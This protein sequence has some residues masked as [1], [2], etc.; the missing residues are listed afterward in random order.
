M[1]RVCLAIVVVSLLAVP[2]AAEAKREPVTARADLVKTLLAPAGIGANFKGNHMFVTGTGGLYVYDIT[3]GD[4]PQLVSTLP[5]PHYENEDVSIGGNRLLLSGDGT[6]GGGMVT[7]VDISN[8]KVPIIERVIKLYTLGGPGH[9]ATCIQGCKYAWVAGYE[10]IYVLNL[11]E[12]DEVPSTTP[13]PGLQVQSGASKVEVGDLAIAREFGWSTHDVQV[14]EAG[15]AWVVGGDGTAAFD[16]RPGSYPV[17]GKPYPQNLLEPKLVARTGPAALNDGDVTGGSP[18]D[19]NPDTVN[20]FIHHNSWRPRANGFRSRTATDLSKK[21]VRTGE[22]VLI[23]EEDIWNRVTLGSTPGG[24]ET[25]GSFQTWQVKQFGAPDENTS[26]VSNLDRWT[27]E[28]NETITGDETPDGQDIVPTKG[29][30]SSHYFS[31]RKNIVATAWYEQGTR[32]LD[33]S[34]PSNIK[35]VAYFM[36]PGST[37]WAAYWSPTDDNVVYVVDNNRGVDVVRFNRRAQEEAAALGSD[38]VKAPIPD[39]WATDTADATPD[40]KFSWVCRLPIAP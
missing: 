26:T 15:Y 2:G 32:F 28:F 39:F 1:K 13:V 8:P 17:P 37:T 19:T 20:D 24:C 11:D 23:T 29:F 22:L 7:V 12:P 6:L 30:C 34:D 33:V 38:V 10:S 21:G 4:D 40:P 25:Q 27:T 35:Q 14:D 31:E 9:T 16:V 36:A 5:M 3:V 18:P